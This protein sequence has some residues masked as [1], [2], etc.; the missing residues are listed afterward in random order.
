MTK[1]SSDARK[2]YLK[3]YRQVHPTIVISLS[4][5]LRDLI[6]KVRGNDSYAVFIT[7]FLKNPDDVFRDVYDQGKRAGEERIIALVKKKFRLEPIEPE[8]EED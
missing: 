1:K 3:E 6:D 8:D 4:T 7:K 2:Q 5:E